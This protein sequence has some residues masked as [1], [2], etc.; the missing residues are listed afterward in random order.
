MTAGSPKSTLCGL[1]K[2]GQESPN[3]GASQGNSP[4]SSPLEQQPADPW[5]VLYE[6]DG[7]VARMNCIPAPGNPYGLHGRGGF[8]LPARK[9][10]PPPLPHVPAPAGTAA[11]GVYYHPFAHLITQRQ[12]QV[13]RVSFQL[14]GVLVASPA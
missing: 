14:H 10:S 9:A 13:A 5:D 3:S 1:P 11:G 8:V 6:A 7:Q 4:P 12:I 2:S